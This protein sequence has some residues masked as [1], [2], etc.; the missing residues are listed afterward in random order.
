[1]NLERGCGEMANNG[2][3]ERFGDIGGL[4]EEYDPEWVKIEDLLDVE[5]EVCDARRIRGQYGDYV[6]VLAYREGETTPVAFNTGSGPVVDK[7]LKALEKNWLPLKGKIVRVKR[8]YDI[9]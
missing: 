3:P 7:V 6:S 8:Y 9:R 4:W 1:M 2:K 5:L